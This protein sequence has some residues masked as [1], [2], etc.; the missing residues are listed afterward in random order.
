MKPEKYLGVFYKY[1]ACLGLI[2]ESKWVQSH[3]KWDLYYIW[4][5]HFGWKWDFTTMVYLVSNEM[6]QTN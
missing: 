4:I 5:T 6:K 3:F 2:F 1:W